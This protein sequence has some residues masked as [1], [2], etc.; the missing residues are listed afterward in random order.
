MRADVAA[1]FSRRTS[2]AEDWPVERLAAARGATTVSVVLPALDE[3]STVGRIVE[4]LRE[5]LGEGAPA[6]RRLVDELVVMD[7]GS[8]DRTAEVARR[9]GARVV[10]RED[11]LPDVPVVP[12]KGEAMWRSLAATTGDVV[13]FVDADLQSFTPAYVSGL[14][15]PLLADYSVALVKAVYERPLV[16]GS[17]VVPAGGGRVTELVARPLLNLLW[18]ELAGVVQPLAGE[19]A[20]RRSLLERLAFPCGYGV[21][22]ALLVDTVALLGLD[23]VAQVDLGVRVHR[24]HDERRLGRMAAEILRTALDRAA[25]HG[26]AASRSGDDG[27]GVALGDTLVQ[28]DRGVSGFTTV[29]HDV[30]ALERPPLVSVAEYAARRADRA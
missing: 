26:S 20:A 1:W 23:A 14:L 3:E 5:S 10:A 22:L 27:I 30:A 17:T 9:A 29:T 25:G 6:H 19:Y 24:H 8:R 2:S 15:G 7:S 13:V 11:V 28:F 21:E 4:S 12:G 18:P 16:E